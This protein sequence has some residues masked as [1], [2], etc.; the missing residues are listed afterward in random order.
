MNEKQGTFLVTG[1]TG[2]Q[3][4]VVASHLRATGWRVRALTR[5]PQKPAAQFL[6]RPGVEVVKGDLDDLN[7]LTPALKT[8]HF[9]TEGKV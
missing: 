6:A 1:A 2:R 8:G 4:G 3:G 7:W 5:D 9:A